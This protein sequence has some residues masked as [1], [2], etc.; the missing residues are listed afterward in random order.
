MRTYDACVRVIGFRPD[1]GG[2]CQADAD[3]TY[4]T[5]FVQPARVV[6]RVVPVPSGELLPGPY[7]QGLLGLVTQPR[8]DPTRIAARRYVTR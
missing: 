5:L 3:L 8:A 2:T 6:P 1:E 4:T 7:A